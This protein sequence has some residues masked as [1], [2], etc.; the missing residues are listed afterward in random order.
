[1]TVVL[2]KPERVFDAVEAMDLTDSD[3]ARILMRLWRIP[4]RIINRDIPNRFMSVDD[5][6]P[7]VRQPPTDLIRGL[8]GGRNRKEDK[9]SLDAE[10]FRVFDEPGCMKL[11][12]AFWMT[13]LGDDRIRVDTETRIF[14]TDARTKRLFTLYWVIIRPWSG[15]IR[16]RL[17]ASIKS[18]AESN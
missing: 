2:G 12:W 11:C 14:C 10:A 3:I 4:A 16:M 9:S 8:I 18:D 13:D 15:L 5:F 1:M 7:L 17:L 6:I